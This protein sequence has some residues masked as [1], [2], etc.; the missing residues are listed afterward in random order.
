MSDTRHKIVL[1]DD[2]I[3]T[4]NQGKSLLQAFYKVYTIQS[5]ATLF[6]NLEHDIPDLI[7][8][9]VEMPEM[10]GFETITKLKANIRYKN[11][12]VIFLTSKSDEESERKGFSLGAVDYITKPFSGPLLQKRISNQILYTRVQNAIK[13]YSKDLEIMV[14]E[15]AKANE[16]TKIMMEKTPLC[17]WLWNSDFEMI[18]CNEAA[19][20]LFAFKDKKECLERY[21]ELYPEYQPEEQRSTEKMKD[22]IKKAF[23]DGICEFEWMYKTLDGVIMPAL[24]ILVRVEIDDGYAVAGYTRDM[25]EKKAFMEE[26]RRAEIAEESNKAKSRFLATMSHEMRTP[27]N[28]IIGFAELALDKPDNEFVQEGRVYL[29][30]IKESAKWLLHII[31]DI[32]DISK[33][34]SGKVELEYAP[35]DLDEILLRCQSIVMPEAREKKLDL[36]FNTEP[37]N[38]KKLIGDQVRLYQVFMNL[39][40]NAIKF[41]NTGTIKFSSSI[42]SSDHQKI[43]IYFEVKDSGIGIN[44]EQLKKIFEPFTQADSSTTRKFGGTGLGLSITKN[45]VELMGGTLAVESA[46]GDGSLFSFEITFELPAVSDNIL[47]K[48][49]HNIS[50]KPK[51]DGLVL[52]CED[53]DM[54]QVVILEHL[55]RVG[56]RAVI[57]DNGAI[58]VAMVEERQKKGEKPFDLIFMDIFMPEMD[59]IEAASKIIALNSESP[60]VAMTANIMASDLENY[61]K[62]GMSDCLGKPF[63]SQELWRVLSKYMKPL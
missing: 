61:R 13:D 29:N 27:M 33:I 40:S 54:N 35:F 58:G 53:N 22:Y 25:R 34:E 37:L 57:A 39:L 8:L 18:D 55:N 49:K 43:K 12:P 15:L 26:M 7:L 36:K 59:G 20:K 28:S 46:S 62:N 10:D 31:N 32:L 63:T 21:H 1:V 45:L 23:E 11:I 14:G 42:K 52:V 51:F 2:N 30:R 24:I 19:V 5:A 4:L 3:A 17:A 60:I 48:E 50:E 41:T 16:R 38:G 9:D 6:E 44:P 47:D 56:I